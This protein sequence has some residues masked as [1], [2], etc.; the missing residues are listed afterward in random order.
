MLL[1]LS[2]EFSDLIQVYCSMPICLRSGW[3]E[4]ILKLPSFRC[5]FFLWS[6]GSS[7]IK[8]ACGR[9]LTISH[10]GFAGCWSSDV[11]FL[12]WFMVFMVPVTTSTNSSIQVFNGNKVEVE[13]FNFKTSWS[14]WIKNSIFEKDSS[15]PTL[16]SVSIFLDD[17]NLKHWQPKK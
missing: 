12:S 15:S 11:F 8:A 16:E 13:E 7:A 2:V 6:T 5:S 10:C 17:V 4:P 1:L 3:I 14:I 9:K